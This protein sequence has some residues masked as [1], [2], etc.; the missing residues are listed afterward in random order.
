MLEIRE[1]TW[2]SVSLMEQCKFEHRDFKKPKE[3]M[4]QCK[5]EDLDFKSYANAVFRHGCCCL[6]ACLSTETLKGTWDS[7]SLMGQCKSEG[8]DFK[9]DY[10]K[11]S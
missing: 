5:S 11:K 2:D 9:R 10:A 3:N 1:E 6:S 7:A 4:G 8:K